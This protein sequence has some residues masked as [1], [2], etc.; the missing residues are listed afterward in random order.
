MQ[1][2]NVV[3]NEELAH[4]VKSNKITHGIKFYMESV[5]LMKKNSHNDWTQEKRNT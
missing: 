1:D 4:R 2:V 3:K 5:W